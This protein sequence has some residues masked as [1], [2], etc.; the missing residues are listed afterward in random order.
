MPDLHLPE[1]EAALYVFGGLS[2]EERRE[3]ETRLAQSDEL[4]SLVR[5]LEEGAVALAQ[6]SP[7]RQPPQQ[8]WK[9]IEKAVAK[10]SKATVTF[11]VFWVGWLRNGWAAA[12]LCLIGWLLY[13]FLANR[14]PTEIITSKILQPQ[15]VS[16]N[17]NPPV[18]TQV[19]A[20]PLRATNVDLK[21]L[22][23][24][25]QEIGELRRKIALMEMEAAQLSRSL[26]RQGAALSESNRIKFCQLIPASSANADASAPP[27]SP[28]LQHAML[29]AIARELNWLPV[30]SK[31]GVQTGGGP[32][33]TLV[34]VGGVDF[35]DLPPNTNGVA[36][37]TPVPQRAQAAT[38]ESS[39]ATIPVFVAGNKLVVALDSTVV[40][41]DSSVAFTV[42]DANQNQTGGTVTLGENP[43]VVTIPLS[44]AFIHNGL[45]ATSDGYLAV[46][47]S[48]TSSGVSTTSWFF[49]PTSP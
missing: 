5:E 9:R 23:A 26:A 15:T 21:L 12:A 18:R 2:A 43:M 49:M 32:G 36:Y 13:A 4:R 40:P 3:F 8:I 31:S 6:A 30:E 20:V 29:M 39:D 7:R 37:P 27:L 24:R 44:D 38:T 17:S 35:V 48:L 16:A 25:A 41:P 28:R 11:P 42:T 14:H 45:I 47:F 34:S 33:Q 22:Q 1:D 46:S 19:A 10:E